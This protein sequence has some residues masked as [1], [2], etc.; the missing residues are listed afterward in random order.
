MATKATKQQSH[1]LPA[2]SAMLFWLNSNLKTFDLFQLCSHTR[3]TSLPLS[4]AH[5]RTHTHTQNIST[6]HYHRAS[7]RA[8]LRVTHFFHRS[9]LLL[10]FCVVVVFFLIVHMLM[11]SFY[12]LHLY[13]YSL[14]FSNF[15]YTYTHTHTKMIKKRIHKIN[16]THSHTD[17]VRAQ[18]TMNEKK[19]YHHIEWMGKESRPIE[20]TLS[21]FVCMKCHA[22][23]PINWLGDG[24]LVSTNSHTNTSQRSES[25]R[26]KNAFS[27]AVLIMAKWPKWLPF[28]TDFEPNSL[29]DNGIQCRINKLFN[30][31]SWLTAFLLLTLRIWPCG[32]IQMNADFSLVI[33]CHFVS[34]TVTA[35]VDGS[36]T[37][38][39]CILSDAFL[40]KLTRFYVHSFM[41]F[42]H[43]NSKIRSSHSH[44]HYFSISPQ[45][46]VLSCDNIWYQHSSTY[47]RCRDRPIDRQTPTRTLVYRTCVRYHLC[48][49][50]SRLHKISDGT[51][52]GTFLFDFVCSFSSV[53]WTIERASVKVLSNQKQKKKKKN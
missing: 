1:D 26:K 15:L 43:K 37:T 33:T 45:F 52:F 34:A 39:F 13:R 3:P 12:S 31:H 51:H 18:F 25:A 22:G 8:T 11:N 46:D 36:A 29:S 10:P 47:T 14:H 21:T 40:Q 7:E 28:R 16:K 48:R 20:S 38:N 2:L 49:Y 53:F 4:Q 35:S 23:C 27:K 9:L 50:R 30:I 5:E 41:S 32:I 44:S 24:L 42:L 6:A 19:P 17:R